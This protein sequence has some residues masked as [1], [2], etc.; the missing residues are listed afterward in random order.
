[1]GR[2]RC[3]IRGTA[4][5]AL[6]FAV[7]AGIIWLLAA[8]NAEALGKAFRS[9]D[10]RFFPPALAFYLVHML[11]SAW[12]WY[13]MAR[14]LGFKLTMSEAVSITMQGYFFS[15]VIPAGAVGGDV[16]RIAILSRRAAPGTGHDGAATVLIDRVV[17]MAGLFTLAM[18][19]IILDM[20]VIRSMS[21][22]EAPWVEELRLWLAGGM[23]ALCAAGNAAVAA[24]FFH[25]KLERVPGWNRLFAAGDRLTKG[26][27]TH[28]ALALDV[29]RGRWKLLLGLTAA[30]IF[31]AHLMLVAS[32]L[33]LA[34]GL[35]EA[36]PGFTATAAAVTIGNIAGLLPSFSG[37]GF[38][39]ITMAALL[40]PVC[41]EGTAA[42]I[43]LGFTVIVLLG[44]LSGG[45]FFVADSL[46]TGRGFGSGSGKKREG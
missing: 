42:A 21:V 16:A 17:G 25:R 2:V 23:F 3:N 32:V 4:V 9:F 20:P 14:S 6:K 24:L 38:R 46:L 28:L 11:V 30:S 39:D 18:V 5:F 44:N 13:E 19:L 7:A 40:V 41:G 27:F 31:G 15:L 22:P 12:R 8:G 35:P 43:P 26:F 34:A 33:A 1:M 36:M 37:I 10:R 45:L 29:Y